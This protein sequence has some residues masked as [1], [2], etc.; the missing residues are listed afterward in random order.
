MRVRVPPRP[1]VENRMCAWH[2]HM[3]YDRDMN[4][5]FF[6][7]ATVDITPPVGVTLMGYDPRISESVGHPLRA[8]ALAC[9]APA[10]GGWIMVCAD[11][12]GFSSPLTDRVRADILGHKY[13]RPRYGDGGALGGRRDALALIAL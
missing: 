13:E 12:C 2:P 5:R 3:R 6:G 11:V 10:G 1:P 9:A 7:V 8:E 4:A